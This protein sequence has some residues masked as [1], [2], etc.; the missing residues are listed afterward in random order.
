MNFFD[1]LSR[2][3]SLNTSDEEKVELLDGHVPS[4]VPAWET[5]EAERVHVV[6]EAAEVIV[7][8]VVPEDTIQ[9]HRCVISLMGSG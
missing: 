6:Q 5:V 8:G 3:M 7:Q 9:C 2:D 4:N 1:P